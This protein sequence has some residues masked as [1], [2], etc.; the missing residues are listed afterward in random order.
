MLT[1]LAATAGSA[2]LALGTCITYIVLGLSSPRPACVQ[3]LVYSSLTAGVISV[4]M[5]ENYDQ[6]PGSSTLTKIAPVLVVAFLGFYSGE[7]L[8]AVA[9][10]MDDLS[11]GMGIRVAYFSLASVV[12]IGVATFVYKR[13]SR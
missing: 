5:A 2:A 11:L 13:S 10:M 6:L 8:P 1:G 3:Y 12:S 7:L 4:G 9:Q